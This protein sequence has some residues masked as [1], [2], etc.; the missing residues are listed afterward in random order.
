MA[1]KETP[2]LCA[3][4]REG[5]REGAE[6]VGRWGLEVRRAIRQAGPSCG[7]FDLA[8]EVKAAIETRGCASY[9]NLP[10]FKSWARACPT[11]SLPSLPP[12]V[13]PV[14]GKERS[15]GRLNLREQRS[16]SFPAKKKKS[17]AGIPEH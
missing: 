4:G 10:H 12:S 17:P 13:R 6:E 3:R 16:V 11:P 5:E 14:E 9:L 1:P 15:G 7:R 8:W 2:E